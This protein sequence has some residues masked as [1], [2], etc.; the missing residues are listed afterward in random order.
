[1]LAACQLSEAL[2]VRAAESVSLQLW[3]LLYKLKSLLYTSAESQ[4]LWANPPS[5][6]WHL[7]YNF[8]DT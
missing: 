2:G 6:P 7:L 8:N 4:I 1:M 3:L 5:L